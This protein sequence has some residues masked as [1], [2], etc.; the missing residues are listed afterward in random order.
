MARNNTQ[1]V[2]RAAARYCIF[3][4]GSNHRKNCFGNIW[5]ALMMAHSQPE[6]RPQYIYDLRYNVVA[7]DLTGLAPAEITCNG[8]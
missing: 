1:A 2:S 4:L 6:L 8:R 5:D 7:C 3:W